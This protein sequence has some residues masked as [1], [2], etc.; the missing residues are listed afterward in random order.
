MPESA[1]SSDQLDDEVRWSALMASA[2]SGCEADYRVLLQELSE[3]IKRYLLSRMGY[4]PSID[5]CVQESLIAVHHARHSYDP[6]RRFR[7]WL[8]AIVRNKSIDTFRRQRSQLELQEKN[9]ELLQLEAQHFQQDGL[10]N[11]LAQGRLMKALPAR[12]RE[13]LALTKFIGLSNAE[14]ASHLSI[15]EGAVKV[16]VHRAIN[17][18]KR[19]M[20]V[21]AR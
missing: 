19:L 11:H 14:A 15:S 16:R 13:V 6:K 17:S 2:Q 4:N 18:L 7:P 1:S 12:H 21:D 10:E 9:R 5:D 20:E 8:F 3:V